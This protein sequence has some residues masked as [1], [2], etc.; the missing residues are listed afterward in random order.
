MI[1]MSDEVLIVHVAVAVPMRSWLDYALPKEMNSQSL[2]GCRVW[3]PLGRRQVVGVVLSYADRTDCPRSRLKSV[4]SVIDSSPLLHESLLDLMKWI[5]QYYHYPIGEVM[6]RSLPTRLR[7]GQ[8]QSLVQRLGYQLTELGRV[9]SQGPA[10]RAK[11]QHACLMF[12]ARS[13]SS[14][15]DDETLKKE[16]GYSVIQRCIEQGWVE[17]VPMPDGEHALIDVIEAP[18]SLTTEQSRAVSDICASDGFVP[19]LLHGVTGS[20]KTEVYL[21]AIHQVLLQRRQ[22]LVLVPEISLTPQTLSRFEKR[23]NAPV[24]SLHSGLSDKKRCENWLYASKNEPLIVIGTRS[25]VFA[26]LPEL[27]MII[28][29]EEHDGSFKQQAGLRYSARDVAVMRAQKENIPIVLGSA[30]P[31]FETLYNV[32]QG[33]YREIKLTQRVGGGELPAMSVVDLKGQPLEAGLCEEVLHKISQTLDNQGQVLLFINRRGYAPVWM[34]HQCGYVSMCDRCDAKMVVHHKIS[35]LQC[36]HCERSVPLISHCQ[37]CQQA[38]CIAV[39][40]G[41]QRLEAFLDSYFPEKQVLR[42]DRDTVSSKK[43]LH[44]ALDKIEKKAVD[45]II[46]TQMVAKGHHFPHL[47]LVVVVDGDAGL[48]SMDYRATE[49]MA[50]LLVQVSGRSGREKAGAVVIQTHHPDHPILETLFHQGYEALSNMILQERQI[51]VLPPYSYHAMLRLESTEESA[52]KKMLVAL[53]RQLEQSNGQV[54]ISGPLLAPLA[55]RAGKYRFQL[56]FQAPARSLLQRL[57]PSVTNALLCQPVA[58]RCQW[59]LD[60]DPVDMI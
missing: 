7:Q 25:A 54:F 14:M 22:V 53:K 24:F 13:S 47:S 46:G 60:V 6:L 57:L 43:R 55:R 26:P 31:A 27:G 39:G 40:A 37:Q 18:L 41:T 2:V 20:G 33:R 17:K 10:L 42:I 8:S 58:K 51:A 44:D 16:C 50:Q 36:H 48:F 11:K 9:V 23:F 34:C 12:L 1:E 35:R 52:A 3:V 28:V 56:L 4:V 29:D 19:W 49:R 30:T 15:V 32:K 38:E 21:Q 5:S 45:I 59:V